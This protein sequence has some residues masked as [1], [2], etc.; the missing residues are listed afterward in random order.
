MA[1]SMGQVGILNVGAGDTKL[2][3]DKDDPAEC[4]RAAR[5]VTDMLRRGYALLVEVTMPGGE[6]KFQRVTE[7]REDTCEYVIADFDPVTAGNADKAEA[8]HEHATEQAATAGDGAANEE[9]RAPKQRRPRR[10][11]PASESRA[12]AI[13]RTAGG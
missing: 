5:I 9:S 4:I 13:G 10:V 1:M 11:I 12:V 6:K 3:F 7:F 8:P 2:V